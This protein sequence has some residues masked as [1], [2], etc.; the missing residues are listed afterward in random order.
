M[1]L[2]GEK[3]EMRIPAVKLV[4][5]EP[6]TLYRVVQDEYHYANPNPVDGKGKA[7]RV[8]RWGK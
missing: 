3:E 2:L 8:E 6:T 1:L 7:Q 4:S 5:R